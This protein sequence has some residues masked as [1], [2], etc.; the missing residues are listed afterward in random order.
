MEEDNEPLTRSKKDKKV[1]EVTQPIVEPM[2]Q[3]VKPEK[4]KKPRPPKSEAQ[5]EAFKKALETR[6]ANIEKKKI[7]KKVEASKILLEH[8]KSKEV[9]KV[10]Q[11]VILESESE[12]EPEIVIVKRKKKPKRKIVIESETDSETESEEEQKPIQKFGKSHQHKNSVKG[13]KITEPIKKMSYNFF[14]D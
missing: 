13:I 3:E 14:T 4:V 2:Q 6:K 7:D 5:L 11:K 10:K 1:V 8:D 9:K 12:S